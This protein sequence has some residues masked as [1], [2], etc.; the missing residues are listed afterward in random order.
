MLRGRAL[1]RRQGCLSPLRQLERWS[2]PG[3]TKTLLRV[4]VLA[5]SLIVF[6]KIS[7][8][9]VSPGCPLTTVRLRCRQRHKPALGSVWARLVL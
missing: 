4:V 3:S 5:V 2:I 6:A 1:V 7:T 8:T 9:S